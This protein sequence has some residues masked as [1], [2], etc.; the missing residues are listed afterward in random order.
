MHGCYLYYLVCNE[1][2][3]LLYGCSLSDGG[4]GAQPDS[5]R[6]SLSDLARLVATGGIAAAMVRVR[7]PA[8]LDGTTRRFVRK[9]AHLRPAGLC[10]WYG[11]ACAESP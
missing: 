8:R 9:S 1:T 3:S 7:A 5:T 6:C 11:Q 2:L 10:R 4:V